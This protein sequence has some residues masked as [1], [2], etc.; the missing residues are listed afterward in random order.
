MLPILPGLA[1]SGRQDSNRRVDCMTSMQ[2]SVT[3]LRAELAGA[4]FCADTQ[5]GGTLARLRFIGRYQGEDVVWLAELSALAAQDPA[6]TQFL[7]IGAPTP[8]GIPIRIGLGVLSID[9]PT[10]MKA[11]IMVRNYK[12]LQPGQHEFGPHGPVARAR[13]DRITG[14]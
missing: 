8:H 4:D 12:L 9:R 13:A 7:D 11:V 1:F 2:A 10:A 3:A 5:L 14:E 6:A